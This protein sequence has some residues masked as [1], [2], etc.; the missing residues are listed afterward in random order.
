VL[1]HGL[2]VAPSSNIE[3]AHRIVEQ[4]GALISEYRPGEPPQRYHFIERDRIQAGLADAVLVVET[5]TQGGSM[6]TVRSATSAGIPVWTTFPDKDL[7]IAQ[8][9]PGQLRETQRG[10]WQ[11]VREGALRLSTPRTLLKCLESFPDDR[12]VDNAAS[13]GDPD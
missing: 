11:L 6:H 13:R 1:A 8:E 12:I 5:G 9:N 7:G 10:T 3:L 4:G 2:A